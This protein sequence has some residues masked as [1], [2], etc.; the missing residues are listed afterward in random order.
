MGVLSHVAGVISLGAEGASMGTVVWDGTQTSGTATLG[1][2]QV[3]TQDCSELFVR[4]V[5]AKVK[6]VYIGMRLNKAYM[7]I[8]LFIPG[9]EQSTELTV[10][11]LM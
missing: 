1:T 5:Y 4:N 8:S 3:I 7:Y 9:C 6:V 2:V 10:H 11:F